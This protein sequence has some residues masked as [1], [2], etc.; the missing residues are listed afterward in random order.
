VFRRRAARPELP[1]A[2]AAC[3][4]H[5]FRVSGRPGARGGRREGERRLRALAAGRKRGARGRALGGD[6]WFISMFSSRLIW[7]GE[8]SCARGG[9]VSQGT[10]AASPTP[11]QAGSHAPHTRGV[12]RASAGRFAVPCS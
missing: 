6:R 11:E 12:A 3:S 1:S 2:S 7:Y 8:G 9:G 10:L 4:R 5:R